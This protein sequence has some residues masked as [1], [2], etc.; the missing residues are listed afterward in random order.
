MAFNIFELSGK[1]S[2]DNKPANDAIDETTGKAKESGSIFSTLGN[3]LK[4]VGAGMVAVAGVAGAAAVGLSKKVIGAYAEYEQLVG[5]VDTLFKEA[6]SKVQGF[7]DNAYKTAGMSANEYM[8]TVTSFSASLI[9]SLGGDTQ[10]AADVGNQAVTDMSD[11]ANKMGTDITNIQNAYQGFAKQ[12]YTMLDNLKLGYG[13]TKEEMQ[14]LL[15]DA[16]K[17]SGVKYDISSFADVTEAIHVMQ[18]QMGITGTT[19]AEAAD[20]ISGSIDSTKSALTNLWAGLGN[21]KADVQKLVND[22]TNS[23]GN[24]VK[25]I[26]PVLNNIVTA[27]PTLIN[28]VVSAIGG[29]LPNLLQAVTSLFTQV[30]QTILTLLPSL[31]PV[32]VNALM[33]IV[34]AIISNLPLLI[35][36]AVQ[37]VTT[38][39]QGIATAL[40][41]LI[42]AAVQAV[43]TIV[44]G[45][46]DN[47]P[48][49]LD[50]GL[51]LLTGLLDGLITA[52]P[53][54]IAALPQIIT[55]L[56]TFFVTSIPIIIN[57][58]IQLL[59][60][61][62]TALPQII[63]AIVAVLPQIINGIITA[64]IAAL[65]QLIN[66]GIQ[67]FL[68]LITALP[69]IISA[70]AGAMPQII[71]GITSALIGNIDQII[72]AGV[73][74]LVALVQN[75]PQI[76]TSIGAAIPQ[77]ISSIVTALGNGVGEMARAGLKLITGVKDS[78]TNIDW[79]S[80]GS[81]IISGV[82][83]GI[84]GAA[85]ELLD[86]A[87]NAAG[88]AL[89]WMKKKL[90]IHSPSR[91]FRD[92]VGKFIPAGIAVGI[93]QEAY[94]MQDA[95]DTAANG[96]TF[97][98]GNLGANII[99]PA[100]VSMQGS[101]Q[102]MNF[103][104][105][106]GTNDESLSLL[107]LMI[108]KIEEILNTKFNIYLDKTLIS[109]EIEKSL[110]RGV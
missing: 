77:I 62:V 34:Q 31:I 53:I 70:I 66:A 85:T 1:I 74:L 56:V 30:L 95:L 105:N 110:V 69:Q 10:K 81:N 99:D 60:A 102:Q 20:T 71:N 89:D 67:L 45:L 36:A 88:N 101:T 94:T 59:T 40:P 26:T 39:V 106:S 35:S 2:A 57:A 92:E 12:N 4:V 38:L 90:G 7:A 18:T 72:N 91:V 108:A 17:I 83:G 13:G 22:V 52:I 23:L 76:M 47:L 84:T 27:L 8:E 87:G 109:K 61:L 9:Q 6:S 64:L 11:N 100:Q 58:G 78:F 15:V 44:Q 63:A 104:S 51:Q 54:L 46:I 98:T 19:A 21:P 32:F 73:A 93:E 68:A 96:L 16:E 14:R 29:M 82:A 5:G 86:A 41:T 79:A 80:V 107:R 55:I 24:V 25:N 42:P 75:L 103:G 65:P 33:T 37:L 97:D 28:G 50:A 43:V 3:G 48:L 49:L